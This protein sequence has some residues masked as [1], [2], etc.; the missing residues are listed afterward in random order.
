[1]CSSLACITFI[2]LYFCAPR[3]TPFLRWKPAP[4]S[5]GRISRT[6][7]ARVVDQRIEFGWSY[8]DDASAPIAE[9]SLDGWRWTVGPDATSDLRSVFFENRHCPQNTVWGFGSCTWLFFYGSLCA[10]SNVV[11]VPLLLVI[12]TFAGIPVLRLVGWIRSRHRETSDL[13]AS[14]VRAILWT[15]LS[16]EIAIMFGVAALWCM[17]AATDVFCRIIESPRDGNRSR[18]IYEA[19]V[20]S[21]R[22]ELARNREW[23]QAPIADRSTLTPSFTVGTGARRDWSSIFH[24]DHLTPEHLKWGFG[25][26]TESSMGESRFG[27]FGWVQRREQTQVLSLPLAPLVLALAILP[28]V[29]LIRRRQR[30]N[31]ARAGLCSN[32]GYDLRATPDRCPECGRKPKG[33]RNCS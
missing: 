29:I 3:G 26:R 8:E 27:D 31:A 22:L 7:E 9:A 21:G 18:G 20:V 17:S 33:V 4:S 2:A 32:C 24:G 5:G 11:S 13:K 19:R 25:T 1:V 10:R 30:R 14:A 16:A 15:V 12:L 23:W 28:A 6:Y